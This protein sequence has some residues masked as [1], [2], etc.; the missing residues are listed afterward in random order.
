MLS[1]IITVGLG[2]I[3]ALVIKAVLVNAWVQVTW[4]VFGW[5]PKLIR[6]DI[7]DN[8]SMFCASIFVRHDPSA[9]TLPEQD[10]NNLRED[11]AAY[12][13]WAIESYVEKYLTL[14]RTTYGDARLPDPQIT[15]VSR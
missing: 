11:M 5:K 15:V 6:Q 12:T 14:G 13:R 10:R 3:A 1:T 2:F 9:A 8:T 7:L 4:K